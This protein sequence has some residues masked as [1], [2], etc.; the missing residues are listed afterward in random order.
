MEREIEKAKNIAIRY[1]SYRP[2][3][4]AEVSK[5]LLDK[6][7]SNSV[8]EKTIELLINYKYLDDKQFTR[9]W[10]RYRNIVKPMGKK[11]L[12]QELYLKGISREVISSEIN[13]IS[14]EEE[15]ILIKDIVGKK[16]ARGPLNENDLIKLK[17]K[18]LRRG[19]SIQL[20]SKGLQEIMYNH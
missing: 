18:L 10:I 4:V 5:K 6:K 2:R 12:I 15:L 8:V 17:Q 7:V 9:D 20:I 1:L 19:F 11:R 13:E 16:L 3:S 14:D